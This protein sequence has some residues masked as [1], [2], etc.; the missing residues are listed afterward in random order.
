M[1]HE[2]CRREILRYARRLSRRGY[3]GTSTGTGG[4]VSVRVPGEALVAITPSGKY[5]GGLSPEDI[6]IVDYSGSLI[7]GILAPSMETGLHLAVYQNRPDAGA[8]IHTHQIC[9]S[10]FAVLNQPI[11]ALFDEAVYHLGSVVEV[12]PY[13]VS[14]SSQLARNVAVKLANGCSCYL[15]QNH[16]A[17]VVEADL[18]KA[19]H[20][21]ELLEKCAQVYCHALSAGKEISTVPPE[22]VEAMM[23]LRQNR[24]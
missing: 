11:P 21:V 16:G 19:Y 5:Y 20:N 8:V 23:R 2:H 15:L 17:L 6:C 3:F 24:P 4:N 7:G 13:A 1:Q 10:V 12:V 22:A 18:E 14:G 9:A